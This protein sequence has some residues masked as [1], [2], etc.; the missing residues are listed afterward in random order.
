MAPGSIAV[1]QQATVESFSVGS[2]RL[3]P[4]QNLNGRLGMTVRLGITARA[5]N[6][7]NIPPAQKILK[8]GADERAGA[9][10]SKHSRHAEAS[11]KFQHS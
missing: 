4:F 7:S 2:R 6:E 9:V 5:R 1:R 3:Q 11:K 8:L 10:A